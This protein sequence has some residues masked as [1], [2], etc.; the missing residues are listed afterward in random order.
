MDGVKIYIG[1]FGNRWFVITLQSPYFYF[2]AESKYEVLE[3]TK[4]SLTFYRTWLASSPL[5][6]TAH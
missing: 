1:S 5:T 3:K 6:P 4:R 2:E